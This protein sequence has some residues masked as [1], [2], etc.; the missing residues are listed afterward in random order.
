MKPCLDLNYFTLLREARKAAQSDLKHAV[1][2]ALLSDAATQQM[3]PL[4]RALLARSG[5]KAV[6]YEG[7]FDAIELEVHDPQ[8]GLYRFQPDVIAVLHCTQALRTRFYTRQGSGAEFLDAAK[9]G[10]E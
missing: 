6:V 8:S 7:G 2:I 10:L 3:V 5:V 9:A 1:R 4:L